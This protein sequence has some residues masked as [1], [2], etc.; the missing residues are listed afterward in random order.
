MEMG[1]IKE[2]RK[3]VASWGEGLDYLEFWESEM[4]KPVE[5]VEDVS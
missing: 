2:Y 3:H 1:K 5:V 4:L